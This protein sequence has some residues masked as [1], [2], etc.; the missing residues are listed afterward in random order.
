MGLEISLYT[1]TVLDITNRVEVICRSAIKNELIWVA[2]Y[3][4]TGVDLETILRGGEG[5]KLFNI[6]LRGRFTGLYF[7]LIQKILDYRIANKIVN[8]PII[9]TNVLIKNSNSTKS[10]ENII[11]YKYIMGKY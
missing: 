3:L 5:S 11:R 8:V 10:I 9:Y 1:N 2:K 7:F 6:Y 4:A